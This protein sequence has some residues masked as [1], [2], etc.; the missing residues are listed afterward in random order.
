M[1]VFLWKDLK[2]NNISKYIFIIIIF[3]NNYI[4]ASYFTPLDKDNINLW[5]NALDQ[6]VLKSSD[7]LIALTQNY[8]NNKEEKKIDVQNLNKKNIIDWIKDNPIEK[9]KF[10]GNMSPPFLS[11]SSNASFVDKN[12]LNDNIEIFKLVPDKIKSD[13]SSKNS[14]EILQEGIYDNIFINNLSISRTHLLKLRKLT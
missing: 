2:K 1:F 4:S 8:L 6:K 7:R 3:C 13:F 9:T 10:Y 5:E 12:L 14:F 11:F